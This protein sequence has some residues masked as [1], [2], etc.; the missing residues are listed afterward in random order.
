I[1]APIPGKAAVGIE[2]PNE[3]SEIVYLRDVIDT[4]QFTAFPS[5][6]AFALGKDIGGKPIVADI[7]KMPHIL[8]AGATGSG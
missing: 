5:K 2:V 3:S 7:G 4:D 8:I 1:E 6:L